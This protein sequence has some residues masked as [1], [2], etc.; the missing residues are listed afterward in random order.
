MSEV[1]GLEQ[2]RIESWK[3]DLASFD[4]VKSFATRCETDLVRLDVVV[5]N[6]GA[7]TLKFEKTIDGWER[8]YVGSTCSTLDA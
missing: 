8:K 3:L 1:T 5:E 2:D 4:S 6:A 7:M